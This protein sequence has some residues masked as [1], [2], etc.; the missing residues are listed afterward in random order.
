[1]GLQRIHEINQDFQPEKE[2]SI[3]NYWMGASSQELKRFLLTGGV[4][5]T[6]GEMKK[7]TITIDTAADVSVISREMMNQLGLQPTKSSKIKL[8]GFQGRH[9]N[10]V[11]D[12]VCKV[13][14]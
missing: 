11:I 7:L 13:K 3:N 1:M 4:V 9:S 2:F 12:E 10:M 14:L 6:T 5:N 8:H